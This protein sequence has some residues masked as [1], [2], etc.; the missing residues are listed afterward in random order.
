MRRGGDQH[1]RSVLPPTNCLESV[2]ELHAVEHRSLVPWCPFHQIYTHCLTPELKKSPRN[3]TNLS[4]PLNTT[5]LINGNPC[6]FFF[7]LNQV[8]QTHTKIFIVN[9]QIVVASN[10]QRLQT[11]C[12]RSKLKI[13]NKNLSYGSL[14]ISILTLNTYMSVLNRAI[15]HYCISSNEFYIYQCFNSTNINTMHNHNTSQNMRP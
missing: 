8:N 3:V 13:E 1:H 5:S 12:R 6:M 11:Q 10:S 7:S 4:R 2:R 15:K 14:H 9:L